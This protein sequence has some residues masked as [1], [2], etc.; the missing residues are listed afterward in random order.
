MDTSANTITTM[1]IISNEVY[2]TT[3]GKDY[4]KNNPDDMVINGTTYKVIDHTPASNQGFNA[5]LLQDTSTGKYVI[6]FRGTQ[7][8]FDIADDVIIGLQNHSYEFQAAK[9]WVDKV[10]GK[11][12]DGHVIEASDLTL[13]GHSLGGILTQA[14][15]AVYQIPG[16]AFNPYGVD[17]LLLMPSTPII[18]NLLLD[19][20]AGA[21]YAAIYKVLSAFGLESSYASWAQDNILNISYVDDGM[22]KGDPLS[23]LATD[24]TSKQ[25]GNVLQIWGVDRGADAHKMPNLNT[26]IQHYNDVL[27]HFSNTTYQTLTDIYTVT[28]YSHAEKIFNDLN[29]YSSSNLTFNFLTNKSISEL[30]S[31]T[32]SN[33]YALLHTNPFTIEGNLPAYHKIDINEYSDM[34]INDLASMLY[35]SMHKEYKDGYIYKNRL[36]G[37]SVANAPAINEII[38]GTDSKEYIEGGSGDDRI[39]GNK[40]DDT[41]YGDSTNPYLK[42][43]GNDYIEGG[44]GED[45]IYG[46]GGN[47]TLDG[48]TGADT[49]YGGD[50]FD[51]YIAGD[52]DTIM[53]S[54]GK[55]AKNG[56]NRPPIAK[57][58]GH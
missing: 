51:T 48:G 49:L 14:V 52:G 45:T 47:D 41:I 8:N 6:A 27:S 31:K 7:E 17:R 34:Q 56:A 1:G 16:Y 21:T 50:D 43:N 13:T 25:L 26:A 53:D 2:N 3:K 23:N 22:L 42:G 39:Y 44:S 24:L 40:G 37:E 5:L 4:F 46:N 15:G 11:E 30:T 55:G 35:S 32:P 12:Y 57:S 18:P 20:L 54:D 10:I 9:A 33:L 19:L 29:I 58:S 36:I 28:G 38:F